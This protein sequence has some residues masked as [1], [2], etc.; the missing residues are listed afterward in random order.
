MS[1]DYNINLQ[2]HFRSS[3]C[4]LFGSCQKVSRNPRTQESQSLHQNYAEHHG[5]SLLKLCDCIYEIIQVSF[6]LTEGVEKKMSR[7]VKRTSIWPARLST[8][9][10][11]HDNFNHYE[12]LQK[13]HSLSFDL[14]K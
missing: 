6:L 8:F 9:T 7:A 14:V 12:S 2:S 13:F 4:P 3:S 11:C 10:Q 5:E 1:K